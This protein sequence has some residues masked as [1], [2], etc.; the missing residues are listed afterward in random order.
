MTYTSKTSRTGNSEFDILKKNKNEKEKLTL[1]IWYNEF[2]L[3]C[4]KSATY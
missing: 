3:V 1:N 4:L 2:G